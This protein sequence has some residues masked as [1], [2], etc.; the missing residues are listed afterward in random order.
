MLTATKGSIRPF[1]AADIPDIVD[2]FKK[3]NWPK[4]AS[5]FETYLREQRLN[6]RFG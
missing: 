1:S 2:A 5:T 6:A 3:A 4:P